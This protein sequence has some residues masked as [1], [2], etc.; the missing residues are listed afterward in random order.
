MTYFD[1][2]FVT[3]TSDVMRD[4]EYDL[5]IRGEANVRKSIGYTYRKIFSGGIGLVRN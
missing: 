2:L 5:F 1:Q 4:E 3:S